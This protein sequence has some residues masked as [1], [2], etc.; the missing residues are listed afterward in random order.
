MQWGAT[1]G[2]IPL[3]VAGGGGGLAGGS[4]KDEGQNGKGMDPK[5][6]NETGLESGNNSAGKYKSIALF[7]VFK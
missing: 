3:L 1:S 7:P 6:P 5:R 4:H 2:R